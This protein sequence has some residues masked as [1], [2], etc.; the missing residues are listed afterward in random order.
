MQHA[1]RRTG[2]AMFD[3]QVLGLHTTPAVRSGYGHPCFAAQTMPE[4][5]GS[6]ARQK[7]IW[8]SAPVQGNGLFGWTYRCRNS[9]LSNLPL[10]FFGNASTKITRFGHL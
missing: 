3:A 8:A 1:I 7:S 2:A 6:K 4:I 10:G 9:R 5:V